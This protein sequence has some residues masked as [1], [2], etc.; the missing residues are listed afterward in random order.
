MDKNHELGIF[1]LTHGRPDNVKTY[2]TLRRQGYTGKIFL[3]V[4]N[5]DTKKQDY[6][7]KFSDQ[8]V[9]FDKKEIA[10]S[11]DTADNFDDMRTIVYARNACFQIANKLKIKYFIQLDDDYHCFQYRFD[12]YLDYRP[13][14]IKDMDTVFSKLVESYI[15]IGCDSIAFLQ[16]GDFIGGEGN[17]NATKIK[18]KRKC[19]NLFV[20][21]TERPF[22]FL[23]RINEDVNTYTSCA[24]K[25]LLL[26]SINQCTLEQSET[27][28]NS[29]GMTEVYLDS[30]TY[31]KSFY[32]VMFQPSSV[33]VF[34]MQDRSTA[35]LHHRVNWECT[36]PKILREDD[37]RKSY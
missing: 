10:K 21:S 17:Q 13:K 12:N 32:S 19:M 8:V 15:D 28:T 16:G 5:L 36:V 6:I 34:P 7:E 4:D 26:L 20:C 1:I 29:G 23:G 18:V 14:V 2:K 31:I 35:R 11:F 25:G 3:I 27:Q 9:I 24:S 33:T 37:V 30:G 22:Q